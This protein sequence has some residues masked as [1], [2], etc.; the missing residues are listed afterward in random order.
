MRYVVLRPV[1][2]KSV[3]NRKKLFLSVDNRVGLPYTRQVLR[4]AT[5]LDRGGYRS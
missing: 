2:R 5:L 1:L 4:N 3:E